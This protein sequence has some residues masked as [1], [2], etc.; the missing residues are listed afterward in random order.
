MGEQLRT[1]RC[2][3]C[4]TLAQH[5]ACGWK[6]ELADDPRDDKAPEIAIYCPDCYVRE[7]GTPIPPR[8]TRR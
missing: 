7:F 4:D 1:L 6:A 5:G 2:V 8:R 3:E